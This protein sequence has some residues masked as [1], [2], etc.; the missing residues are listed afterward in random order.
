MNLPLLAPIFPDSLRTKPPKKATTSYLQA[1]DSVQ[2]VVTVAI[3]L[4]A[5]HS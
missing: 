4:V 1:M 2:E 5:T 3:G